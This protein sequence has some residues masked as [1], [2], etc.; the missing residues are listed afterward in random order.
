MA[1]GF[2]ARFGVDGEGD[3]ERAC[4]GECVEGVAALLSNAVRIHLDNS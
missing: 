1:E 4:G 2:G 3:R